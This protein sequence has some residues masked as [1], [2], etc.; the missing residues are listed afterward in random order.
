MGTWA[1]RIGAVKEWISRTTE[2]SRVRWHLVDHVLRTVQRYQLQNGDRLAGA[3]TY[4]AFLSLFPII[5]LAFAVFGYVLTER[6]ELSEAL[7]KSIAEQLPGLVDQLNLDQI[8][9][10]RT[11]AG[12]IG[13]VGLL[14]AGMGAIDAL[15][16]AL[17]EISMATTPP[18]N[19]V[20]GK[21]RDL[22]T[23]IMLGVTM[24]VSAL[25]GGFATQAT[26]TVAAFLGVETSLGAKLTLGAVGLLG[27]VGADWVMFLIVLGWVARPTRPFRTLA[28]GAL[29]GAIGFGVLKQVAT[30]LLATT[31]SNPVYGTFAVTAGLLLWINF[32]ARLTLYVAAWTATSG[33]TPP[34][35]PTPLPSDRSY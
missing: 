18:L 23:L 5:A 31:L 10:A 16:G 1:E 17:R 32:S 27:S 9:K 20:L 13:L 35:A 26:T 3:V 19:F 21:L 22:A 25:V 11:S 14:Y 15:R 29:L 4:F 12:V 28:R 8:A 30:L 7:R 24:V 6:P 34:P 33:L 2:R